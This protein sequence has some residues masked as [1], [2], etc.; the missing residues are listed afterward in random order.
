M[1]GGTRARCK[2][3]WV[4]WHDFCSGLEIS[5]KLDPSVPE[6]DAALLDSPTWEHEIM[7]VGYSGLVTRYSAIRFVHLI[8]GCD[9]SK[10]SFRVGSLLNAIK[11]LNPA[12]KKAP[13]DR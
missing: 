3:G 12:T 5:P 9:L 10:A 2:S 6:W 7:G 1:A 13:C 4:D 11:R 8:E